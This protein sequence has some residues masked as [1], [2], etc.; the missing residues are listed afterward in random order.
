M[1]VLNIFTSKPFN[2]RVEKSYIG[3]HAI[4]LIYKST[5]TAFIKTVFIATYLNLKVLEHFQYLLLVG[6]NELSI[7]QQDT[8]IIAIISWMV[9]NNLMMNPDKTEF[10]IASSVAHRKRL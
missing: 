5:L 8:I 1:H 10:V 2:L 6:Y 9:R 3:S 4:K 7:R